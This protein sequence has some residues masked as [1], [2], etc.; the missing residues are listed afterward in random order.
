[1]KKIE[2]KLKLL[3]DCPGVYLMKDRKGAVIYA[4]KAASLRKRV[5]SYFAASG[6]AGAKTRALV[7][8]IDDF[9]YIAADSEV[10]ALILECSLIKKYRPRYNVRFRDD[11]KYPYIKISGGEYPGVYLARN[12]RRDGSSYYGPY[13]DASA[14]REIVKILRRMFLLRTCRGSLK[15]KNRPCLYRHI[16][17]C[18]GPCSGRISSEEYGRAAARAKLFLS[19][20]SAELAREFRAEMDAASMNLDFEKAAFFRDSL[21]ALESA[22]E[23]QNMEAAGA[24]DEDYVSYVQDGS[25]ILAGVLS[26]RDGRVVRFEHFRMDAGEAVGG[27]EVLSAF[28]KQKYAAPG[29]PPPAL[30]LPE[31]PEDAVLIAEWLRKMRGG[32]VGMLV[33]ARGRRKELLEKL[34]RNL[35]MKLSETG[36]LE[37]KS[38]RRS[39]LIE[40]AR[41]AGEDNPPGIIE[42]F[43]AAHISGSSAVGAAVVFEDGFPLRHAYRRFRIKSADKAD[44]VSM[45]EE[46]ARRRYARSVREGARLPDLIVVDGGPAQAAAVRRGLADAGF[47]CPVLGFAKRFE[48]VYLPDGSVLPGPDSRALEL[49]RHLRDEAHRTAA[50]Y[51]AR[52]RAA[53]IRSSLLDGVSGLGENKKLLLL[54]EFGGINKIAAASEAELQVVKGVGPGL[55]RRIKQ[56]FRNG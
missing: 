23:K 42:C 10:E 5:R 52:R 56:V 28:I 46:I 21:A 50:S 7:E 35:A 29:R 24:G 3:P 49:L 20:R 41:I 38:R 53:E 37:R 33:P 17:R 55:A 47:S 36:E 40:L 18:S 25:G 8:N 9:E 44:D 1:M 34:N 26:V 51:H 43:D 6:D 14:A 2:E 11:K 27:A 39:A 48:S 4:G 31:L 45:I 30:I 54:R 13:T 32:K 12:L 16:S 22:A 15:K 19:G